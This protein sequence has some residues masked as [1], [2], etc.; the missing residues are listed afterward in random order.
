MLIHANEQSVHDN[1][2]LLIGSIVPRPIAFVTSMNEEGVVNAAPFSFFNIV[3]NDPPMIMFSCNRMKD[4]EMKGTSR[5]I[6]SNKEFVVH[7][8]DEDN[9][10][11]INYTSINAPH[12][13]SEIGLAGLTTVPAQIVKVPR[14]K[15][16][17]I[18][19]ECR[20]V[21]HVDLGKSDV[22]IGEVVVFYVED[23]LIEGGRIDIDKLKPVSRLAGSTY[24]TIGP[25]FDMKRPEYEA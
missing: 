17:K 14:V 10:E 18:A 13:V 4:G 7:I 3:N 11:A 9:I 8:V 23:E 12:G 19:M 24:G 22:I 25:T 1:Y 21:Q 5:N 6:I 16:C 2:K 15:E 20:L